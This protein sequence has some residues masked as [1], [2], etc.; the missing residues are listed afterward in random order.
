[1]RYNAA[2]VN[3]RFFQS[4]AVKSKQSEASMDNYQRRPMAILLERIT[5]LAFLSVFLTEPRVFADR[6]DDCD[7]RDARDTFPK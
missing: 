7:L 1:M 2:D 3:M 4:A 6:S 5:V